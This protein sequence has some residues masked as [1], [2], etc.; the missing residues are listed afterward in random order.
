LCSAADGKTPAEILV[1]AIVGMLSAQMPFAAVHSHRAA[2]EP[3]KSVCARGAGTD[4]CEPLCP[5]GK[6]ARAEMDGCTRRGTSQTAR[7]G[8]GPLPHRPPVGTSACRGHVNDPSPS[9][10]SPW[11]NPRRS[12]TDEVVHR[13]RAGGRICW[14]RTNSGRA[15]SSESA[16]W[17]RSAGA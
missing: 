1:A 8:P 6:C 2:A 13:S 9:S 17:A 14:T 5:P 12:R 3:V 4:Q 10:F 7:C 16:S 11:L 15:L